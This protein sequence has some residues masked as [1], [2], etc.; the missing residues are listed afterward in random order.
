MFELRE[1]KEKAEAPD[2]NKP[3][4]RLR[5]AKEEFMPP[6][7]SKSSREQYK[8]ALAKHHYTD[9]QFTAHLKLADAIRQRQN[10]AILQLS[11]PSR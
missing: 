6:Q 3:I 2:E 10:N 11:C 4:E 7:F 9:A 5:T 1:K 8:D